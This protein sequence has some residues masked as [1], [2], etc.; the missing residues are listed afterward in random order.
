MHRK[1]FLFLSLSLSLS[2]DDSIA[3]H[4]TKPSNL[5]LTD[6]QYLNLLKLFSRFLRSF[7]SEQRRTNGQ[8]IVIQ[9]E[10]V[11]FRRENLMTLFPMFFFCEG[12]SGLFCKVATK[13]ST[14]CFSIK[15]IYNQALC[16]NVKEN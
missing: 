13:K 2:L 9:S 5:L 14:I 3:C 6:L 4:D 11:H 1:L 7:H 16:M 10:T 15:R 12:K 8:T